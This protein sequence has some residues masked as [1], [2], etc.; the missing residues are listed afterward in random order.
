MAT[1]QELLNRKQVYQETL[2]NQRS[3]ER[4]LRAREAAMSGAMGESPGNTGPINNVLKTRLSKL[5]PPV[6]MPGNIGDLD[7]SQWGYNI[8]FDFDFGANPTLTNA[9]TD[10]QIVQITQEAAFLVTH[11]SV[12]FA[13]YTNS[14]AL[15]P[16]QMVVVD[17]QSRRQIMNP[18]IPIQNFGQNSRPTKLLVPMLFF[19]N[20]QIQVVASTWLVAG[21]SLVTAGSSAFE[22]NFYGIRVFTTAMGVSRD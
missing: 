18:G 10:T 8:T 9:T 2:Q 13:D 5:L 1:Y 6:L 20:S 14:G 3:S 17:A 11:I 16:W 21:E 22:V 7:Y 12:E 19:P 15:G 4:K